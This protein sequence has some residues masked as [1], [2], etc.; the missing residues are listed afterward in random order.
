MSRNLS[1]KIVQAL[2]LLG[3]VAGLCLPEFWAS[4]IETKERVTRHAMTLLTHALFA[5]AKQHQRIPAG[6]ELTAVVRSLGAGD[7]PT[8]DGWGLPLKYV[9]WIDSANDGVP[10][11]PG[12]LLISA[13]ADGKLDGNSRALL[14]IVSRPAPSKAIEAF[15]PTTED[16]A[17]RW[18]SSFDDDI[19][20]VS[21]GL[22]FDHPRRLTPG[23][24]PIA[25]RRTA[26]A[27]A[28]VCA[29]AFMLIYYRR[30]RRS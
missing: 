4:R 12:F 14:E 2:M 29:S 26:W 5:Y 17:K 6:G 18:A 8:R 16:R 19:I 25:L 21:G 13:G 23:D 28:G 20:S 30:T 10:A 27:V 9:S 3:V 1:L 22:A 7:L 15:L 24:V 11:P